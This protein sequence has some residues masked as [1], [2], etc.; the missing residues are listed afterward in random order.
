MEYTHLGRTELQVS[1]IAL[2][3]WQAGG[4]GGR[5][6]RRTRPRPFGAPSTEDLGQIDTIMK[7][8]AP[9]VGPSPEAMPV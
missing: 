8:A 9:L 3:L 2:G 4:D 5:W 1:R 7:G 6:M